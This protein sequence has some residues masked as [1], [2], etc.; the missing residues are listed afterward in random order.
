[1]NLTNVA[2]GLMVTIAVLIVGFALYAS[3]NRA[4]P[5]ERV[6]GRI[7]NSARC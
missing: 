7:G 3:G 6:M 5:C 4:A 1:M 2:G